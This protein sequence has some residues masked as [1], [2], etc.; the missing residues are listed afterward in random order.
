MSNQWQNLDINLDGLSA[1]AES[2]KDFLDPA[3][4]FLEAAVAI[5]EA[6][7]K[8]V[9]ATN[10]LLQATLNEIGNLLKSIIGD[11]LY[12]NI[13][14]CAHHNVVWD[15]DWSFAPKKKLSAVGE[16]TGDSKFNR[17]Y[18][19]NGDLPW[20]SNGLTGWLDD[21][22]ASAYNSSN[23]NAPKTDSDD[24]LTAF[25]LVLAFPDVT[26]FSAMPRAVKNFLEELNLEFVSSTWDR[27]N[28]G[29]G[30]S[31]ARLKSGFSDSDEY[32]LEPFDKGVITGPT[33]SISNG[34]VPIWM[35][36]SLS[37][38]FGPTSEQIFSQIDLVVKALKGYSDLTPIVLM[39][40][41]LSKKVKVL[42]RA[43]E[44]LDRLI[45]DIVG[46]FEILSEYASW[47][48]VK[49]NTGG[50][51]GLINEA[52]NATGYPTYGPQAAVAGIVGVMSDP[53]TGA[54]IAQKFDKLLQIFGL[55]S[56]SEGSTFITNLESA[57][58]NVITSSGAF[59]VGA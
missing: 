55:S 32:K 23:V 49:S 35:S 45:E 19:S 43:I 39:L 7:A 20:K 53:S 16:V 17:N 50:M 38:L 28:T 4:S 51:E 40:E 25:F 18:L 57:T 6:A 56:T 24:A 12:A 44:E 13:S 46:M 2:I 9:S 48:V 11:I 37:R 31:T 42:Q 14:L 8:L 21:V 34:D 27:M 5:I 41:G 3:I 10:S 1:T 33:D 26:A 52:K 30:Q 54:S 22:K 47:A 15:D 59:D 29:Y 58:S 36:V